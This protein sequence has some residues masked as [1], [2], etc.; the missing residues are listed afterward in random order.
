MIDEAEAPP[1]AVIL[2]ADVQDEIDLTSADM[3][4][5]LI[6]ELRAK[7]I[8]VYVAD[9]HAPVREF[10]RRAGLLEL[11]GEDRAFPTLDAAVRFVETTT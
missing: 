5:G 4:K 2:D 11:V 1:R 3:L 8:A 9:V 7:N 6:K 10:S